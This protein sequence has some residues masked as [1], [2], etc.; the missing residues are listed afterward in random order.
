MVLEPLYFGIL[1][2]SV[3]PTL[4][5]LIPVVLLAAVALPWINAYLEDIALKVRREITLAAMGI[6][7]R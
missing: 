1:P 6:K 5:F 2:A 3:V 7:L 4:Y